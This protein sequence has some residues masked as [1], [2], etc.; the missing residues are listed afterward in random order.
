MDYKNLLSF[1][2]FG[3]A[4]FNS[5]LSESELNE[6]IS[7]TLKD[8]NTHSIKEEV[9]IFIGDY[10]ING[11]SKFSKSFDLMNHKI[12]EPLDS[13]TGFPFTQSYR[14]EDTTF[15][16]FISGKKQSDTLILI[17]DGEGYIGE[18]YF[19]DQ[20]GG[21]IDKKSETLFFKDLI[22]SKQSYRTNKNED[23]HVGFLQII[24]S[25]YIE[26]FFFD[27]LLDADF[28]FSNE[29]L[30]QDPSKF[31]ESKEILLTF[32]QYGNFKL[33]GDKSE[34]NI[35]LEK[36]KLNG[37]RFELNELD[38]Y[39]KSNTD[40][41]YPLTLKDFNWRIWENYLRIKRSSKLA[42]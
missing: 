9:S 34:L 18:D 8:T 42:N 39:E 31:I 30:I 40:Q 22:L 14:N 25:S 26:C 15:V 1:L 12:L 16:I 13:L 20:H 41:T 4:I 32:Y 5:C 19:V 3:G 35:Q 24:S 17:K 37:S 28:S 36:Y 27:N 6:S 29:A 7:F 10:D 38:N 21:T 23:W 2:L 11:H 33:N